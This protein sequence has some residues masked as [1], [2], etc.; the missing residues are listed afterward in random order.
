MNEKNIF[1]RDVKGYWKPVDKIEY[2][3]VFRW[4]VNFI[5]IF[6]Y[7]FNLPGFFWPWNTLYFLLAIAT[8]FFFSPAIK[9]CVSFNLSWMSIIF[10]RNLAILIAIAGS[11]HLRLFM[12]RS[13]EDRYQYNSNPLDKSGKKWMF[14]NQTKDNI[15][16]SCIS[17]SSIWSA[18]E[19]IFFWLYANNYLPYIEFNDNPIWFVLWFIIILFW[20]EFHFYVTHRIIHFEPL[21]KYV[22]YLHH[23]N[24][25]IG[26]WSGL[27]MH[28]IEHIIYFSVVLI[29]CIIP[30]HPLHFIFNLQHT[31]LS[32]LQGHS[33]YDKIEITKKHKIPHSSF[34]HYLH[35]KHFKCNYGESTIPL[36]KWFGTFYDGS[37]NSFKKVFKSKN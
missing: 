30:S 23:K 13:Q 26:P 8:W 22:H 9:D 19:I 20:R 3:P 35:H 6:K 29:H 21:Y 7:F 11:L 34:F 31:A 32:P 10:F 12:L 24:I 28:P 1:S 15:F 17:G 36:D 18:Y 14:K 33:G 2:Q 27:S 5:K 37:Q 16:W 4:P 25:K